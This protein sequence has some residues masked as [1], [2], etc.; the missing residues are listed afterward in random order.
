LRVLVP[1]IG[2]SVFDKETIMPANIA[3][4]LICNKAVKVLER[5]TR[6]AVYEVVIGLVGPRLEK[7][8]VR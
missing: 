4:V 8:D 3:H 6:D 2:N 5:N 7:V 1:G